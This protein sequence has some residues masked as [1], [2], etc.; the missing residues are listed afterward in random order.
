MASLTDILTASQNIVRA[1]SNLGTTFLQV[2]GDKV[3]NGIA[4]AAQVSTGQGRL[5]RVSVIIAGSV[6][7]EAYDA[8]TLYDTSSPIMVIPNTVGIIDVNIPTNN[9]IVIK[10]GTGQV[11]TISYS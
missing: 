9:G 8:N 10:P 3:A 5:A 2:Q 7:G 11:V 6:E 4:A 1:L